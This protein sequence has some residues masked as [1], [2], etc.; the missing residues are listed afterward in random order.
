MANVSPSPAAPGGPE[1]TLDREIVGMG[2]LVYQERSLCLVYE[3]CGHVVR[4][5][6][7]DL[8]NGDAAERLVRAYL[9]TCRECALPVPPAPTKDPVRQSLPEF[10]R[11]QQEQ[12]RQAA[13]TSG[14][15]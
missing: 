8:P 11:D 14:G 2:S 6:H 5:P 13:G 15:S 1:E 7:R 4:F 3:P 12:L 9:A 10:W